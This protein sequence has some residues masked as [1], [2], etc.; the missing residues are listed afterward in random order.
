MNEKAIS[1]RPARARRSPRGCEFPLCDRPHR[2]NGWC[3]AHNEQARLG[4]ELTPLLSLPKYANTYLVY[5]PDAFRNGDGVLKVGRAW[6]WSRIQEMAR[7]GAWIII[8]QSDTDASWERE[9]LRQLA[10]EFEPAFVRAEDAEELLWRGRGW[11]ECFRVAPEDLD[12]AYRL[13]IRGFAYGNEMG[14]NP[15]DGIRPKFTRAEWLRYKKRQVAKYLAAR[16]DT[17]GDAGG[18]VASGADGDAA[19][20]RDADRVDPARPETAGCDRDAHPRARG[21]RVPHPLGGRSFVVGHPRAD[22]PSWPYAAACGVGTLHG[23]RERG[24]RRGASG[25]RACEGSRASAPR[26]RR[27][28]KTMGSRATF[29]TKAP[30]CAGC[31]AD[32]LP[33]SPQRFGHG[34]LWSLRDCSGASHDGDRACKVRRAAGDVRAGAGGVDR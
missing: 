15:D 24:K 13:T 34:V 31:P 14:A 20:G 16:A 21:G 19:V 5:W 11:T 17:G 8:A 4:K 22:S 3:N 28:R 30:R 10:T 29:P 18:D 32:R 23:C 9:A 6:K 7:T 33:G 12:L 2:A 27:D 1:A 25:A 26:G